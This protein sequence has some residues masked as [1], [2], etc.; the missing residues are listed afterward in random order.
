MR[1]VWIMAKSLKAATGKLVVKGS[2]ETVKVV[3]NSR[4]GQHVTVRGVG[5]LMG[6]DLR[7]KE[8]LSL[9]RPI[10]EQALFQPADRRKAG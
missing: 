7:I 1:Y 5:A 6:S 8:G 4:T 9:T 10:A 2:D 3:R